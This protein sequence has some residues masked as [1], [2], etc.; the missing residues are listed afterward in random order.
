MRH[1]LMLLLLLLAGC[2]SVPP[3]PPAEDPQQAW[4]QHRERMQAVQHWRLNGRL[5]VVNEYETWNT[6]INWQQRRDHYDI[7]ITAPLGQGAMRL[8]GDPHQVVLQSHQGDEWRSSDPEALLA[9]QLGW[10]VPVM[11]LRHWVLG[12]PGSEVRAYTLNEAGLLATLSQGEW[13]IEFRDYRE[14]D[15][16]M[17]PRRIFANNHLAKVRLIVGEWSRHD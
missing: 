3:L 16:L 1:I 2:S 15:G 5:L 9:A 12:L 11:D 14:Y 13:E 8:T 4:L 10:R 17:L 6:G 7:L